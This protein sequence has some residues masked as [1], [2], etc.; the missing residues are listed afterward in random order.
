[1]GEDPEEEDRDTEDREPQEESPRVV[2]CWQ[3]PAT[4]S[5]FWGPGSS[6]IVKVGV[7]PLGPEPLKNSGCLRS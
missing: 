5:R 1:M 4:S 3:K 7:A 2:L 6:R